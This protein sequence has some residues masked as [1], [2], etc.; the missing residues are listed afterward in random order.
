MEQ[1]YNVWKIKE[2]RWVHARC[3]TAD[4]IYLKRPNVAILGHPLQSLGIQ[5]DKHPFLLTLEE[6]NKYKEYCISIS[7]KQIDGDF[8]VRP[9]SEQ[10]VEDC[11][12]A[13]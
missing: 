3:Q 7:D 6:A 5:D 2:S 4:G 9:L 1:F 11:C 12:R 13:R 10:C 8:E